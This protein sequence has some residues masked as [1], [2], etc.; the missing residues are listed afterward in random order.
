MTTS[1]SD[2]KKMVLELLVRGAS[3]ADAARVA[4]VSI[5]YITQLMSEPE[6]AKEVAV[7]KAAT[8][9]DFTT[10]EDR[11]SKI[12]EMHLTLEEKILQNLTRQ[13]NF[14]KPGEQLKLLQVVSAKKAPPSPPVLP[15]AGQNATLV[16]ISVAQTNNSQFVMN[17]NKQIVA[18]GDTT[19]APMSA[20]QLKE[21]AKAYAA[22]A[23]TE[24]VTG[25]EALMDLFSMTPEELGLR[26]N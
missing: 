2:T 13:V 22:P 8:M 16:T 20:N 3:H 11:A 23:L 15:N 24:Q 25:K 4:D 19:L 9:A 10:R 5:G 7:R 17:S 26:A 12:Y 1:F 6:F 21:M 14:M 18:V